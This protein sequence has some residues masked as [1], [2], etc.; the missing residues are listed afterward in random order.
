MEKKVPPKN[1]GMNII[2]ATYDNNY[3][4]L[5]YLIADWKKHDILNYKNKN[6]ETA[7]WIA[8]RYGYPDCA[9]ILLENGADPNIQSKFGET[10]CYI[11]AQYG[12][13]KC[14]TALISYGADFLRIRDLRGELPIHVA[15]Y[16][17][18][19]ECVKILLTYGTPVNI[20][21]K[22]GRTGCYTPLKI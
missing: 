21:D 19:I 2:S 17:N 6:G 10:T 3:G 4:E 15:C 8:C 14:L 16:H 7:L 5:N 22:D 13:K 11:A 12:N 9:D 20:Q 18:K 1:L